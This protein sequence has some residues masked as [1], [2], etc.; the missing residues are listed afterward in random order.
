MKFKSFIVLSAIATTGL[1][2]TAWFTG[3]IGH[4]ASAACCYKPTTPEYGTTN[5]Q[6]ASYPF[7]SDVPVKPAP[8][9]CVFKTL[10]GETSADSGFV[11]KT[12]QK[13]LKAVQS[14]IE[15]L[16]SA[17][18]K[19]GGWSSEDN[20]YGSGKRG[21]SRVDKI[22][23]D[24]RSEPEINQ[25]E[26]PTTQADPAS[27][28]MAC[29]ALMR[30]GNTFTT[31]NYS[32]NLE[33]GIE[34]LCAQTEKFAQHPNTNTDKTGTQPQRKLGNN[35][36]VVLTSQCLTNALYY[37]SKNDNR[38]ARVRKCVELCVQKIQKA[39]TADG[40]FDG[41]GWAGVLQSSFANQALEA[42]DVQGVA[43]DAIVLEKSRDYQKSNF[44]TKTNESKTDRGAGVVLY[45]VS[46]STRAAAVESR[47]AKD[48]M[49][50]A[51]AN[52]KLKAGDE[53]NAENLQKAGL[54]ATKAMKYATA[55]EV[56]KQANVT[57][58]RAD[59]MSGFGN[60][61]GE[62]FLSFLQTGEGL[63]VAQEN[64]DKWYDNVSGKLIQIQNQDGSWNGH[65]CITSP[66]FC[67]ATCLLVMTVHN[68]VALL[69]KG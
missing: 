29:M 69:Q 16:V 42:A 41:D 12:P 40:S 20:A 13:S 64:W 8:N 11:H 1:A 43:V 57:A 2:A 25:A 50:K 67:T 3:K 27:T 24:L 60:N 49:K 5:A 63:I 56:N 68:E 44:D 4:S 7:V 46:S 26:V 19:D 54:D 59:V 31:G 10:M 39:Q 32:K 62:E 52:G 35:I 23:D 55:Y 66:V 65:H 28:A 34:Y 61:G 36:D 37:L 18:H 48:E 30:C 9:H 15:W 58:Q 47:I 17:Q 21:Y 33:T 14:G 38:A 22:T 51:K 53:L 6:L 45:S